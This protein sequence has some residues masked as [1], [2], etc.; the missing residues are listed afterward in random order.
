[1]LSFKVH[2]LLSRYAVL[3]WIE[4]VAASSKSVGAFSRATIDGHLQLAAIIPAD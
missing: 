4:T 3:D 1:M 2:R